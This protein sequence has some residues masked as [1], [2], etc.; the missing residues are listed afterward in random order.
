[1]RLHVGLEHPGDLI[2]DLRQAFTLAAQAG[3][4][5]AAA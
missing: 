2:D 1:V 3:R 4:V 5:R